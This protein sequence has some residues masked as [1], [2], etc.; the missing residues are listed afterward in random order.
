MKAEIAAQHPDPAAPFPAELLREKLPY[1]ESVMKEVLRLRPPATLVPHIAAVDFPL[2]PDYTIPKG[3]VVFPSTFESSF[4]V[5]HV[6]MDAA[7]C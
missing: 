5:A 6:A 7:M 4:Q 2:T 1:C 3:T